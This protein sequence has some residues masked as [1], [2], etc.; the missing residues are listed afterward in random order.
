MLYFEDGDRKTQLAGK[1]VLCDSFFKRLLGALPAGRIESG[2]ALLFPRCGA[3]H[4]FFMRKPIDVAY[5]GAGGELLK[6]YTRALP[7]RILPSGGGVVGT[8]EL[9]PG[10]LPD[11]IGA[12]ARI[13]FDPELARSAGLP[14]LAM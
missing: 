8:L 3:V 5:F 12:T 4:T 7:R 13:L 9:P 14:G 6:I 1:V 2:K 11:E 10:C